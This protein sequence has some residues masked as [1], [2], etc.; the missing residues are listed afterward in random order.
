MDDRRIRSIV[1]VGGGTAGWMAAAA[2][3][4]LLRSRCDITLIESE[5]IGVIGVGESTIPQI[6]LFNRML[7]L[8]EDEFVRKTK[9]T[10]KLAIEFKDWAR[11]GQSYIHPLGAIGFD[12]EGVSFH[13]Y[14]LKLRAQGLA[15]SF[16]EYS[17]QASAARRERF[18]RPIDAS[19]SPLSNIPYAFQFDASLYARF[20][21]DYAEARGLK[22]REGKIVKVTQR[23]E[24]G[25]I[26]SV[27]LE[28]G[29]TIA[30][31]LFLDCSGFAALL[32]GKTL[33]VGYE[34]WS[35]WLPCDSAM[36]APCE[37]Q[38][39]CAPM[40]QAIA[41]PSGWRWRIPLQ[42]RTG[43]GY[44]YSSRFVSDDEA[45]THLLS[46][47]DGAPLTEPKVLRFTTGKRQKFWEKNCVAFGLAA[48]FME[49]L[50]S[51]SIHLI[52]SGVADF[53]TMFPDRA[54]AQAEIDRYNRVTSTDWER[55]RDF[56]VLHYK[57]TERDDTAF[58]NYCRNMDIPDFLAEKIRVFEGHGRIF[59]EGEELFADSSWFAV[60]TGQG[61]LPTSYDPLVDVLDD[62]E[63]RARLAAVRA[64]ISRAVE[65]MPS[66]RDFLDR[67]TGQGA[68]P[69]R[70]RAAHA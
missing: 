66:H 55:I 14:W 62:D 44:V 6:R 7:A 26:E 42:H 68:E 49:P 12:I 24:D 53:I 5:E 29:E 33:G 21:R 40:T 13:S 1:I 11:L 16:E 45:Q 50:E 32:I 22:R 58:W 61:L 54:F 56:L 17:L 3:T 37:S 2:F 52:Q 41:S 4:R 57:A 10:F 20:L 15:P 47:L 43:N 36:V 8:D 35:H 19:G 9:A 63:I 67:I 30:A 39:P 59:R 60:M 34:D 65:L 51:Q 27:T 48:G 31:D 69:K 18:M 46:Q 64:A 25:F 23:G 28:S 70:R 38:G